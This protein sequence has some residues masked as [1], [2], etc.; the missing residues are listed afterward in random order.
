MS[1]LSSVTEILEK[2]C[3]CHSS[4]LKFM[5]E[6]MPTSIFHGTLESDCDG[7]VYCFHKKEGLIKEKLQAFKHFL[8]T[9]GRFK[10]G[11]RVELAETPEI[12][13]KKSW[14]WLGSKHYLI[15][16]AKATVMDVSY[17][18]GEFGYTLSIDDESWKDRNDV[19]HPRSDKRC[20]IP[21]CDFTHGSHTYYFRQHQLR[22]VVAERCSFLSKLWNDFHKIGD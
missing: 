16:G 22:P 20:Q 14:G 6:C 10:E 8:E 4:D 19:L 2:D 7:N 21:G 1:D 18:K 9:Q 3:F 12:T 11:D 15:E 13:E 5:F 17:Y